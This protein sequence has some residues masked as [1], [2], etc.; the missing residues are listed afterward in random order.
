MKIGIFTQPLGNNYGGILQAWALQVTLQKMGH[1][2]ITINRVNKRSFIDLIK[3]V[4]SL[5]K[6]FILR[7]IF[8]EN[9]IIRTW[10]TRK[11]ENIIKQKKSLFIKKIFILLKL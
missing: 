9:I 8:G 2:V 7:N 5:F 4:L 1:E 3:R 11:E 10:L 6:R